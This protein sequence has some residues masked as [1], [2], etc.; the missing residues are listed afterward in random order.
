M[1]KIKKAIKAIKNPSPE[2]LAQVE[3]KSHLYQ[4][5]GILFVCAFLIVK[6]F[7]YI[8][9]ALIF[10]VGISYANGITAYRKYQTIMEIYGKGNPKDFDKDISFTRRRDKINE[11]VFGQF[12]KW[13]SIALAVSITTGFIFVYLIQTDTSMRWLISLGGLFM[14]LFFYLLFHYFIS[15]WIAYPIYK[16]RLKVGGEGK[17]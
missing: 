3:Y 15:Y 14:A 12:E 6:G 11:S 17:Q 2:R 16:R 10:G 7:W 9:F 1:N 5:L 8:I 4:A 13:F